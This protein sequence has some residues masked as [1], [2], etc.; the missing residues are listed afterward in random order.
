MPRRD[1]VFKTSDRVTLRGWFFTPSSSSGKLPCLV[2]A[3]G[4][5]AQNEMG[6]GKFAEYFASNSPVTVLA[7]D[8][9]CIGASDGEPRRE[10]I[11][12]LSDYSDDITSY[13]GGHVLTVSAVNRRV[14]AVISQVPLISGWETFHRIHRSNFIPGAKKVSQN[15]GAFSDE[16]EIEYIDRQARAK[17]EEPSRLPVVDKDPHA[18]SVLPSEGSVVGYSSG[19]PSGWINDVTLQR[20]EAFRAYEPVG[21]IEHIYPTPLLMVVADTDVVTTTD[22]TLNAFAWAKEPKQLHLL[23]GGHFDLYD[24]HI[25]DEN[26]SI[27]IKFVED[28]LLK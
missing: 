17:G 23:P 3:H 6:L 26:I 1:I 24:G 16:V 22:L 14:K 18:L 5:A 9:R 15:E 4:F 20:L 7:Y 25:Y 19:L 2:M 28:R 11:P 13:T 10:I 27:Q 8:N 12:S 21:F